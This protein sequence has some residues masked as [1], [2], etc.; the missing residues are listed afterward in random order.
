MSAAVSTVE[1][2]AA[3]LRDVRVGGFGVAETE[4]RDACE[5]A[6]KGAGF[7]ALREVRLA[8][9][10]RADLVVDE[11]VVEVKCGRP[12]AGA[13]AG[14]LHRYLG[15]PGIAGAVAVT[16]KRTPLPAEI[17]GKPVASVALHGA[18]GIALP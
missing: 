4:L 15:C 3:A 13:L 16:E 5:A 9:R 10:C 8:P 14:Q 1:A 7:G 6:L 2:V 12:H 11:M 17:D 18:W